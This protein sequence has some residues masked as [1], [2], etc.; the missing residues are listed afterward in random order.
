MGCFLSSLLYTLSFLHLDTFTQQIFIESE[1]VLATR[2]KSKP[3]LSQFLFQGAHS[4]VGE[5]DK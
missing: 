4:S 5:A 1:I 2:D 3:K